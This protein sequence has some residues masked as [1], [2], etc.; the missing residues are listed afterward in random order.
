M[1]RRGP[2]EGDGA[3]DGGERRG[4]PRLRYE[5]SEPRGLASTAVAFSEM[6][7]GG[8]GRVTTEIGDTVRLVQTQALF[9]DI[10]ERLAQSRSPAIWQGFVCECAS[11]LCI[12]LIEMTSDQYR[13]LRA[14]PTT[15]AV[16]ADERH[17]FAEI[18]RVRSREDGYWIVERLPDTELAR[19]DSRWEA[20]SNGNRTGAAVQ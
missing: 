1:L 14:S 10:N 17:V 6:R 18:E 15:F 13:S 9:K 8:S 2:S 5:L 19:A 7:R 3:T 20:S 4:K 11:E 12:E 16:V